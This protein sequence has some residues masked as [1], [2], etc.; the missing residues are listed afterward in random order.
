MARK[1]IGLCGLHGCGKSYLARRMQ[2]ILG[3]DVINKR[4]YLQLLH[5]KHVVYPPNKDWELWYR[6]LY[7][8][9]GAKEVMRLILDEYELRSARHLSNSNMIIVDAVH[10]VEEWQLIK[11]TYSAILILV[12]TPHETR[13]QRHLDGITRT[14]QLDMQRIRYGHQDSHTDDFCLFAQA[15]WAF[16]GVMNSILLDASIYAL[17]QWLA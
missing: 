16:S 13:Y 15:E 5:Q 17:S 7:Q 12:C 9:R 6:N 10:N 11:E 4:T 8:E 1:I 3:Y 2:E 14:T